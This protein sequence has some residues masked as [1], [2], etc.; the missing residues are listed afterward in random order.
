MNRLLL[1]P[2]PPRRIIPRVWP[3]FLLWVFASTL[4]LGL[5]PT[6][7]GL[8]TYLALV[9]AGLSGAILALVFGAFLARKVAARSRER[10]RRAGERIVCAQEDLELARAPTRG[11]LL[12]ALGKLAGITFSLAVGLTFVLDQ[13]GWTPARRSVLGPPVDQLGAVGA[14]V[15]LAVPLWVALGMVPQAGLTHV[16]RKGSPIPYAGSRLSQ[17]VTPAFILT[18]LVSASEELDVLPEAVTMMRVAYVLYGGIVL[19]VLCIPPFLV[20]M[21]AGFDRDLLR[22]NR[23]LQTHARPLSHVVPLGARSDTEDGEAF[24]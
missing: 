9:A 1:K 11:V 6:S 7:Q 24:D 17:A 22:L 18:L 23:G 16:R 12:F 20:Y 8:V 19:A 10:I 15:F 21:L 2:Q 3:F 4:Y 14:L 13:V 5:S